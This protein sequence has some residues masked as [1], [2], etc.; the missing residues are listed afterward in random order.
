[1]RSADCVQTRLIKNIKYLNIS[2]SVHVYTDLLY[3]ISRYYSYTIPV[4]FY[5]KNNEL[6]IKFQF[7]RTVSWF[8][9]KQIIPDCSTSA[10]FFYFGCSFTVHT[11]LQNFV[12]RQIDKQIYILSGPGVHDKEEEQ[13]FSVAKDN[14]LSNHRHWE[15]IF[16]YFLLNILQENGA[17]VHM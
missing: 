14:F 16:Q 1:M 13:A 2:K 15:Y 6:R 7:S 9:M 4:I 3:H 5:C 11:N 12:Y 8:I 10:V 17:H